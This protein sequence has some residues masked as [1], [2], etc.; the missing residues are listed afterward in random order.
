MMGP[1]SQCY[2][3]SQKV[4]GLLVLEK[5]IFEGFDH[6]W[7]WWPS[8]SCDPDSANKLLFP[9]PTEASYEIWL[10]LAQRFL[11]RRSLKIV[12]GQRTDN[13]H[14]TDDGPRLY[15]K[16]T[17]EPKGSGELKIYFIIMCLQSSA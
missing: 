9:Y 13:G 2:K 1:R 17:N 4:I 15:Y 11:R 5:K 10:Q 14:R 16:F 3:P 12:D 6:I 8:C 7:A